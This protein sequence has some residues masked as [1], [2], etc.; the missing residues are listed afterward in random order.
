MKQ[1]QQMNRLKTNKLCITAAPAE[2]SRHSAS[3]RTTA[4]GEPGLN[5]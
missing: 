5:K 2:G 3:R 1:A 4:Q